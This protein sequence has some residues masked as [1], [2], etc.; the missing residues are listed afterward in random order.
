MSYHLPQYLRGCC[1]RSKG[2][3]VGHK[4]LFG[5]VWLLLGEAYPLHGHGDTTELEMCGMSIRK[6]G[7][8]NEIV[9]QVQVQTSSLCLTFFTNMLPSA[10]KPLTANTARSVL[11][12]RVSGEDEMGWDGMEK[13]A[14]RC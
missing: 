14:V 3:S 1:I 2:K 7:F 13:V 5:S 4:A 6:I 8:V 10:A 12:G 9:Q 11:E